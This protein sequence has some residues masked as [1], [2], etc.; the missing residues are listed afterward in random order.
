[1]IGAVSASIYF[2]YDCQVSED[3]SPLVLIIA[4]FTIGMIFWPILIEPIIQYKKTIKE[5][6]WFHKRLNPITKKIDQ[7]GNEYTVQDYK[8]LEEELE[9]LQAEMNAR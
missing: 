2:Y 7:L 8:E 3:G 6:K 5:D 9:K 1:M 4:L